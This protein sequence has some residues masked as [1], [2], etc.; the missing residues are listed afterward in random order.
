MGVKI[1]TAAD[2]VCYKIPW[3]LPYSVTW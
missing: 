1:L 2:F 3:Q